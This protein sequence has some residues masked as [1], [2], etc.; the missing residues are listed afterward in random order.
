LLILNH[1]LFL[2]FGQ[3]Q[4]LAINQSSIQFSV[5]DPGSEFF[6]P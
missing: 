2:N 3:L 4:S 6:H 5:A 1:L